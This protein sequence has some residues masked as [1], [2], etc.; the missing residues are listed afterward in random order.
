[1]W[2]VH[3][4]LDIS[5]AV[6]ATAI[7]LCILAAQF[8]PAERCWRKLNLFA[9][10]LFA[11]FIHC[12]VYLAVESF[13]AGGLP[14]TLRL[15]ALTVYTLSVA[16]E[17]NHVRPATAREEKTQ[18]L[19]RYAYLLSWV[20]MAIFDVLG[21]INYS[22]SRYS[23]YKVP[24]LIL[25]LILVALLFTVYAYPDRGG[26]FEVTESTTT[27]N[28]R[29]GAEEQLAKLAVM[30]QSI[31]YEIEAAGGYWR[32]MKKFKAFGPW[33]W[34]EDIP[35]KWK[36]LSAVFAMI[37][38]F[39]E[40]LGSLGV[41]LLY[42]KFINYLVKE[43]RDTG[44]LI[45]ILALHTI[46]KWL[47]SQRGVACLRKFCWKVFELE[48]DSQV[49]RN[50]FS[51][52]MEQ[53]AV[54]HNASNPIDLNTSVSMGI[55]VCKCFD[56]MFYE[57][58]PQLL[59]LIAASGMILW[60][61][62]SQIWLLQTFSI[63][64][65][66][67]LS[68]RVKRGS[69]PIFDQHINAVVETKSI[70][71]SALQDW[72]SIASHGQI[73]EEIKS[74]SAA[75]R[76]ENRAVLESWKYA[77]T[78]TFSLGS[79]SAVTAVANVG[80]LIVSDRGKVEIMNDIILFLLYKKHMEDPIEFFSQEF[81]NMFDK[82]VSAARLR[83]LIEILPDMQD[84]TSDVTGDGI[85]FRKVTFRYNRQKLVFKDIDIDF[86]PGKT[87]AILGRTGTGKSTLMKM[88]LRLYDPAD[89]KVERDGQDLKYI[90]RKELLKHT[91]LME[92]S[93]YLFNKSFYDNIRLDC[94]EISE[95]EIQDACK[96]AGIH[97]EIMG[98][99]GQYNSIPGKTLSGGEKQ[100]VAFARLLVH[101]GNLVILDEPTSG[102]DVES[103]KIIKQV[104]KELSKTKT[105][106]IIAQVP[107]YFTA[108]TVDRII[109]L[110]VSGE[111]HSEIAEE[112]THEE[113][114]KLEGLYF[115]MWNTFI[116]E[117]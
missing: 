60:Y 48:R 71:Q 107:S 30:N 5:Q 24:P 79:L 67:L 68:L 92:Q 97:N 116:G 54:F 100:K 15:F 7:G 93:P 52:L 42:T 82:F 85:S 53:D 66:V 102:Q 59:D 25:R 103:E 88:I 27:N 50:I 78:W 80:L 72:T 69:V 61:I 109:V 101:R 91:A 11:I 106:I 62:G 113:L 26:Y 64:L 43:P 21:I 51:H 94:E 83:R 34:P 95:E 117:D 98:R 74:Q 73:G 49:K 18:R 86:E 41:P 90:K 17:T 37:L 44:S 81:Q 114:L 22:L 70:Q 28:I 36:K 10:L 2:D 29:E 14:N 76:A 35:W 6:I 9:Y 16:L 40:V 39:A 89:G 58:L 55:D 99:E 3:T 104:I 12:L 75:V 115:Q 108:L 111:G 33:V 19:G 84:G 87:T 112:G 46:A 56:F 13:Y 57:S 1:M 4:V 31:E 105:V 47:I 77:L 38:R 45:R 32:W 20:L 23:A 8:E 110:N 65:D 63:A 96:K